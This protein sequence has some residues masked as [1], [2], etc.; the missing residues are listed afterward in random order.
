VLLLDA[1]GPVAVAVP[2]DGTLKPTVGFRA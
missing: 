2:R 1:G